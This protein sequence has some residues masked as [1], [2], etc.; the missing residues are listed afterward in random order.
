VPRASTAHAANGDVEALLVRLENDKVVW[1]DSQ[2]VLYN[3]ADG[4]IMT[5]LRFDDLRH[6][7]D[8]RL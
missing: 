4:V 2:D 8:E 7:A 6:L 1:I 5:D 3:R